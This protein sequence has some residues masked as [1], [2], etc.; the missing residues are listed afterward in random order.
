MAEHPLPD[1]SAGPQCDLDLSRIESVYGVCRR[2]LDALPVGVYIVDT[3][4]RI[5]YWNRAAENLTGYPAAEILGRRCVNN[6][7]TGAADALADCQ[8]NCPLARTLVDGEA[9]TATVYFHHKAGHRLP[10][11]ISVTRLE[12][13]CGQVIGAIESFS[14]ASPLQTALERI[15]TL[16]RETLV[17]GLT[18]I[19]SR[20]F[21]EISLSARL[22]EMER[23]GWPFGVLFVDIDR[24]KEV[25]D[26]Y[27]H[28][29]GD[30]VLAMVARTLSGALRSFDVAGRFGG[31][32]MVAVL[33]NVGRERPLRE[34]AERVRRLV[35]ASYLTL[36]DGRRLAVS[37]SVGAT[38]ARPGD[39]EKSLIA[40]A[41]AA[42]Y[43]S[44]QAGRNRVTVDVG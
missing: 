26:T 8:G 34:V 18:G 39:T 9:R 14:D 4:R 30:R 37:V 20:R 15:D 22:D 41:D 24:F 16:E 35:E 13:D 32:E 3:A 40:R 12:D 21:L 27:G 28:E 2:V 25:N 7:L 38:R 43:A 19:G 42:M 33:P 5:V 29:V 31:E 44:K 6:I 23:Y 10:V 11:S 36:D 17:D 1:G